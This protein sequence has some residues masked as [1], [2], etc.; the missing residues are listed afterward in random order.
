ML[1]SAPCCI[2]VSLLIDAHWGE[3]ADICGLSGFARAQDRSGCAIAEIMDDTHSVLI[4]L[5]VV[6]VIGGLLGLFLAKHPDTAPPRRQPVR[7][8]TSFEPPSAWVAPTLPDP[9]DATRF[10]A[11]ELRDVAATPGDDP[12]T[13]KTDTERTLLD[14]APDPGVLSKRE[15]GRCR[16]LVE[17]A[18]FEA[19]EHSGWQNYDGI[20]L[21]KSWTGAY[22]SLAAEDDPILLISVIEQIASANK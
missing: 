2:V 15:L 7:A 8:Q 19:G 11:A 20:R 3:R 14:R 10:F 21:P 18:M 16:D 17:D 4:F 1:I 22:E 9:Q 5:G 12:V 13:T 6:A